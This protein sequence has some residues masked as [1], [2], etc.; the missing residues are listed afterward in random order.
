[1]T[2][3]TLQQLITQG[4]SQK[5]EFKT[6]LSS[7]KGIGQTISAFSNTHGGVILIGID[8]NGKIIGVNSG[9]NTLET[10]ANWIKQNTDL[11][12]SPS[13]KIHK[14]NHKDIIKVSVK[15][16]DEKP[17]F[18]RNHAFQRVGKTNQR[19]NASKIRELAKQEKTKLH[20]DERI[21]HRAT[22][23]DIDEEKIKWFVKEAKKQ[24]ALNISEGASLEKILIKL[25][26][27]KN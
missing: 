14:L 16:S 25:I 6:S 7:R 5:M 2:T 12:I 24:R 8:D 21:C 22:L 4:E 17:V 26:K 3:P 23:E 27:N 15:E 9:K 1:M 10:L 13:I 20:W 11:P 18:F 19:I